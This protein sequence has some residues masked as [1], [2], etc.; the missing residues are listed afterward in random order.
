MPR[1]LTPP[2]LASTFRK[3]VQSVS[4][5]LE[6]FDPALEAFLQEHND[7][8]TPWEKLKR[9][10]TPEGT[11]PE[12]IWVCIKMAR[13]GQYR[14]L[15]FKDTAHKPF[16]YWVPDSAQEL[17]HRIDQMG[18]GTLGLDGPDRPGDPQAERYLVTSLMEEAISSSILEGAV[19]TRAEARQMLREGRKPRNGAERM[20]LN[21]YRAIRR[22]REISRQPLS[23]EVLN[24]IHRTV[25]EGMLEDPS[26]AGRF[27]QPGE[28]RVGVV[29]ER[30]GEFVHLPPP[31][32]ELP[33][34]MEEIVGFAND[35]HGKPFVHPVVRAI[36]VHFA[37][38]YVHPYV[39]GNGR[40]ARAAFYW[41][42]L[43]QG[44]WLSEYLAIS[45]IIRKAPIQYYAAFKHSEI[46][47]CDV[48]Y[49]ILYHLRVIDRALSSFHDYL[50]RKRQQL[51][52]TSGRLTKYPALNHRQRALL[53]EALRNPGISY[54]FASHAAAQGVN[55]F[56]ARSD[57]YAL[58][59]LGLLTAVRG[60]PIRFFPA[61][62]LEE[63]LRDASR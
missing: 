19:T 63:L 51:A 61:A 20:V 13:Q 46:D 27:Q 59:A 26:Q 31:A 5:V 10:K 3:R 29:D 34:R 30:E 15:P 47:D 28:K 38:A 11:A 14:I 52:L 35:E 16:R 54:T 45:S 58:V 40:T 21:N 7:A 4:R 60:R 53:A 8:Y 12:D 37:I 22:I 18:S 33:Q 55:Y 2:D 25:T 24:E 1:I 44:Y 57:L 39:D 48:T 50:Q 17:L 41:S 62:N 42:M 56:T 6:S 43:H 36:L 32:E 23:I 9:L 49:F